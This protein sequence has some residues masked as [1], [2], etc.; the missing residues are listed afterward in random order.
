MAQPD[1]LN[2]AGL[3]VGY[4]EREVLQGVDVPLPAGRI[5]AIVGANASG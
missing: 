4:G 5:T 2:A 1:R 3:R